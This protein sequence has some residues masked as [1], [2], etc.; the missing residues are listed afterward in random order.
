MYAREELNISANPPSSLLLQGSVPKRGGLFLGAYSIML[1]A[2][3][4]KMLRMSASLPMHSSHH[5]QH[6]LK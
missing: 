6:S 1:E 5:G 2:V 3:L 4:L